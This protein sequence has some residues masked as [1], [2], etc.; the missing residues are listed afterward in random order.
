MDHACARKPASEPCPV[1][2]R[3]LPAPR[4]SK[5]ARRTAPGLRCRRLE[6]G[7][8]H[9]ALGGERR[10]AHK[11]IAPAVRRSACCATSSDRIP[12]DPQSRTRILRDAAGPRSPA[13]FLRVVKHKVV[14]TAQELAAQLGQEEMAEGL[15]MNGHDARKIRRGGLADRM[16]YRRWRSAPTGRSSGT[17]AS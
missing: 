1:R 4:R 8:R 7:E 2:S 3:Q 6:S 15:L 13:R 17:S 11:P 5:R 9:T 14:V 16:G 12:R 10:V